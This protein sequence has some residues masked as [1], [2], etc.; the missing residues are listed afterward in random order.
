MG[1]CNSLDNILLQHIASCLKADAEK[2][3]IY[4]DNDNSLLRDNSK[5]SKFLYTY[6]GRYDSITVLHNL[7]NIS[8]KI[9]TENENFNFR[10]AID[11]EEN[12]INQI[13]AIQKEQLMTA[14][15]ESLM[16]FISSVKSVLINIYDLETNVIFAS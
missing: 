15:N 9:D 5:L 1:L 7:R 8:R 4:P 12:T 3:T 10:A 13:P 2:G 11:N 16:Y 6:K 14:L